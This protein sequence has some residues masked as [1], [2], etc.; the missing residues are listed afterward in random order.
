MSNLKEYATESRTLADSVGDAI[1]DR[2]YG[3]LHKAYRG[4]LQVAVSGFGKGFA[5]TLAV[6]LAGTVAAAVI[7]PVAVLGAAYAHASVAACVN[8]GLI[9]GGNFLLG[10][11]LGWLTLGLGSAFGSITDAYAHNKEINKE[12]AEERAKYYATM[13]GK[14]PEPTVAPEPKMEQE[15][16]SAY[17]NKLAAERALQQQTQVSR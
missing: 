13:R 14:I 12:S 17:Q 9:L 8:G 15:M 6:V 7:S 11:S 4:L 2:V 3:A 1:D 5:A 10:K 16:G